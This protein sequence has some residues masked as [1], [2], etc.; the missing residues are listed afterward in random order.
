MTER[1]KFPK[2]YILNVQGGHGHFLQYILDKFC[3]LTP[4]IDNSPFDN[5]GRSHLKYNQSGQFIFIEDETKPKLIKALR[6]LGKQDPPK[7][8]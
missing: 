2:I 4:D 6:S 1:L 3:T 7:P 8:G 5:D